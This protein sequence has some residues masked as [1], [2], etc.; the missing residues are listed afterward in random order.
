MKNIKKFITD[1]LTDTCDCEGCN[2]NRNAGG[3]NPDRLNLNDANTLTDKVIKAAEKRGV[4]IEDMQS[5][6]YVLESSKFN[7]IKSVNQMLA[8]FE[9]GRKSYMK[10]KGDET[11]LPKELKNSIES[12]IKGMMKDDESTIEKIEIPSSIKSQL[13]DLLSPILEKVFGQDNEPI[14]EPLPSHIQRKSTSNRI[15]VMSQ[16]ITRDGNKTGN[17]VIFEVIYDTNTGAGF[18]AITD[19]GNIITLTPGSL[20]DMFYPP[21]YVMNTLPNHENSVSKINEYYANM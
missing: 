18:L 12:A 21:E 5:L 1:H 6:M 20:N 4:L 16:L 13:E 2:D 14:E 19:A 17:A 8:I 11:E 3:I 9:A 10:A 7:D 15:E